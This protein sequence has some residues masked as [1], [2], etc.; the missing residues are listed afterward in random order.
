MRRG[1]TRPRAPAARSLAWLNLWTAVTFVAFFLGVA[2]YG[3]VVVFTLGASF[4]PVAV[5]AWSGVQAGRDPASTR[6]GRAQWWAVGLLAVLGC[7]LVATQARP[8]SR[9]IAPLLA[10]AAL[11]VIDGMA[12]GGAAVVSRRLGR[13][14]VGVWH[15]MAHRY[16]A[17][18]GVAAI[19][20]LVL[21]PAGVLAAPSMPLS[22]SVAA[23]LGSLV[24]PFFLIQYAIQRLAPVLVTTA[25]A[26]IPETALFVEM[27]D[28]RAVS[29]PALML[30]LLIVPA[31]IAIFA[32]EHKRPPADQPAIG[33]EVVKAVEVV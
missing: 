19:A 11:G 1:G 2:I 23:A 10:A 21:V 22:V 28:G 9:G 7:L 5:T 15:V 4:A 26:L 12:A 13:D 29:W 16:Y 32:T 6:P 20:L 31:S 3:A 25:L 17:T 14:G 33:G 8:D 24:V 18:T 30:G 27:A